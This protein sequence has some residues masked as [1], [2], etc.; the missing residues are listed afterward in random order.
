MIKKEKRKIQTK[1]HENGEKKEI[2]RKEEKGRKEGTRRKK[3]EHVEQM[4]RGQIQEERR[5]R[6]SE[7]TTV[8]NYEK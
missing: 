3:H 1:D 8:K 4:I 6:K 2:S 7:E 5:E